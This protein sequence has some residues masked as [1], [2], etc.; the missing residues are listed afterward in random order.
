M[1]YGGAITDAH[2]ELRSMVADGSRIVLEFVYEGTNTGNLLH[3]PAT[4]ER[5][6]MPMVSIY[7][8]EES[9]IVRARLYYDR[10]AMLRQLGH[11]CE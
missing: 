5:V 3:R 1:F 11:D 6:S 4:G 7:E 9:Y 2:V 10:A 8:I